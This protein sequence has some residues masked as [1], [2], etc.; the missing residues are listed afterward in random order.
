MV[1]ADRIVTN[2]PRTTTATKDAARA[3]ARAKARAKEEAKEKDEARKAKEK[4]REHDTTHTTKTPLRLSLPKTKSKCEDRSF[5]KYIQ[6]NFASN[7]MWELDDSF[8]KYLCSYS[9]G[10]L[11]NNDTSKYT[12]VTYL[13][14]A[15][16]R[17]DALIGDVLC[18][19]RVPCHHWYITYFATVDTNATNA[20]GERKAA[21]QATLLW[22]FGVQRGHTPGRVSGQ[23]VTHNNSGGFMDASIMH[24]ATAQ[25]IANVTRSSE[26]NGTS[27][28]HWTKWMCLNP[29]ASLSAK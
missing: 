4:E 7:D 11:H 27:N 25:I 12:V 20:T 26:T 28:A 24:S 13:I 15:E 19:I 16:Y 29:L 8:K 9:I 22:P 10:R 21:V 23:S 1:E 14:M 6:F 2:I 17:A 3:R 5:G 18:G